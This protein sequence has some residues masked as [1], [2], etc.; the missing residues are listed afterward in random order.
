MAKTISY[1]DHI[2]VSIDWTF[3]L[4]KNMKF[5]KRSFFLLS[6]SVKAL[7]KN[8]NQ[9][10]NSCMF[11]CE[12]GSLFFFPLVFLPFICAFRGEKRFSWSTAKN[13]SSPIQCDNTLSIH[14]RWFSSIVITVHIFYLLSLLQL[15][16]TVLMRLFTRTK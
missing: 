1:L 5:W 8:N 10:T 4:I 9:E 11:F 6:K 2:H 7:V 14:I 16:L 3:H 12:W 13:M 15:R